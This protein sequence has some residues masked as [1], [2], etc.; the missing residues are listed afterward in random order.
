M[1]NREKILKYAVKQEDRLL[2]SKIVDRAIRA[3]RSKEVT[4]SD[5]LDPSQQHILEKAMD[6]Q[7]EVTYELDGG[8]EGAE[9]AVAFFYPIEPF[10]SEGENPIKVLNV[11]VKSAE[12]LSHRD[13]LGTLMGLGIKREKI[14]DILVSDEGCNIIS[15]KEVSDYIYYNLNKVGKHKAILEYGDLE[16]LE[17]KDSE[18]KE[19]KVTVASMRLDC[20]VSAGYRISRSRASELIKAEKVSVNWDKKSDISVTVKAGDTISVRGRGRLII[21]SEGS[22]TK[23]GRTAVAL[24]RLV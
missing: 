3:S 15:H 19:I 8:Y 21:E 10:F 20:I 18:T 14:G 17:T 11:K 5:F 1:F 12:A 24:N 22:K 9:R 2:L 23:K 4:H 6:L 13:Y 16:S 7:D